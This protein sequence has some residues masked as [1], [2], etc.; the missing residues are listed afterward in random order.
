MKAASFR[1]PAGIALLFTIGMLLPQIL[2]LGATPRAYLLHGLSTL[3]PVLSLP[4]ALRRLREEPAHRTAWKAL[5]ALFLFALLQRLTLFSMLI[6][7]GPITPYIPTRQLIAVY[8]VLFLG[9]LALWWLLPRTDS[10]REGWLRSLDAGIFA[11]SAHL[12]L[13]MGLA[14]PVLGGGEA[15]PRAVLTLLQGIFA[16]SAA[17]LGLGLRIILGQRNLRGPAGALALAMLQLVLTL[18]WIL[19]A[20]ASGHF[21]L[22]HPSLAFA[23]CSLQWLFLAIHAPIP[24]GR[25]PRSVRLMHLLPYAP[26][27]LALLGFLLEALSP[28]P[29]A[30][31]ISLALLGLLALAVLTRQGLTLL[32]MRAL[33]ATLERRVKERTRELGEKDS[34]VLRTQGM[35][36]VASMGAGMA[37]DINN[38]MGGAMLQ[39]ELMKGEE[40]RPSLLPEAQLALLQRTLLRA[41][42][43][44]SR[45]MAVGRG[46]SFVGTVDLAVHLH[47][48]EAML[49]A[50]VPRIHELHLELASGAFPV[51]A[52]PSKL[53]QLV[54]NLVVNARDALAERGRIRVSLAADAA[55]AEIAVEDDG[56]GIPPDVLARIFEPFFTTKAPGKGTG[57]G[58]GSVKAVVE[59]LGGSLQVRTAPG[60]GSCFTLRLPL[61]S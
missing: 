31:R 18:P 43:L 5:T 14:R 26:A 32:Q 3:L 57:L 40:G 60:Q 23:L 53:D 6:W 48:M 49:R 16:L 54:V 44:T 13:W 45:L 47:G 34:L 29:Q 52:D 36:L 50:L 42:E 33:N 55:F 30:D 11:L 2:P 28:S 24:E 22:D 27:A 9:L 25:D 8:P 35:N 61:A 21:R 39:A 51:K 19:R 58:L 59:G 20:Q 1:S 37:H 10:V 41:G 38:L 12:L 15:I 7:Q 17:G 4:I 46:E 56:S